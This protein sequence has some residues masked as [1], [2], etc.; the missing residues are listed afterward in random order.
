MSPS[1]FPFSYSQYLQDWPRWMDSSCVDLLHP[2]AYRYDINSYRNLIIE[3]VG[4]GTGSS[5]YVKPADRSKLSPGILIKSGNQ[6]NRSTYI[7]QAVEFNRS[8]GV[9]G[10]VFFFY[11]GLRDKNEFAAD[12]L[13][14]YF[15][16]VPAL[17]PFRQG[18]IRRPKGI[19]VDE[20]TPG[21]TIKGTW[22]TTTE[23]KGHKGGVLRTPEGSG[24]AIEWSANVPWTAWYDVYVF[25]PVANF[26]SSQSVSYSSWGD[27]GRKDTTI[28]QRS[29]GRGWVKIGTQFITSGNRKF[30]EVRSGSV[31]SGRHVFADGAMLIL[32]RK[33]SP[34]IELDGMLLSDSKVKTPN[35]PVGPVLHQN[36]PNPFNPS[37]SIQ[38]SLPHRDSVSIDVLD[39]SGKVVRSVVVNR[40]YQS[41]TH[42]I[43]FDGSSLASGVYLMRMQTSAGS[44]T[45]KLT[46]LK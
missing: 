24:S 26:E 6:F 25:N 2:Q 39:V 31:N 12:S 5:G 36:F 35:V 30:A 29:A 20:D 8:R 23:Y 44:V 16:N 18:K 40:E 37:T 43:L 13:Y 19:I 46:L 21:A 7:R 41:G 42:S 27:L 10:E 17:L 11:E 3:L 4:S 38:F 33:L 14:K 15:Y 9:N 22:S 34:D 28:N 32:N 45:K 1:I